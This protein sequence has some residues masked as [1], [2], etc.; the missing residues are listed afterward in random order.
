MRYFDHDTGAASD[1]GIMALRI[2]HGG[3]AVDCYWTLLEKMYRDEA[4]INLSETNAET[5]SVC[6]RLCI[7]YETL[8]TYVST[9]LEYGLFEGGMESLYSTR[10]ML[11]ITAYQQKCETAR[12]NGKKG[13]RKPMSKPKRKP[14]RN[15][16]ANQ[17]GTESLAI[18]E[19]K[20]VGFDKQNL[21]IIKGASDGAA[22]GEPAPSAHDSTHPVCPL[23]SSPVKLVPATGKWRCEVCGDVKEPRFEEV[24][25]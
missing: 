7:G 10:A 19:N 9:M 15:Q 11:N 13:G 3:A 16:D 24:G 23:C 8:E 25:A 14:T 22:A 6:H 17:S 2:E 1:D 20:L 5:K 12:Q 18:K 21:L 4:P